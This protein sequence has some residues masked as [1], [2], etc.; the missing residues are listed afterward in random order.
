MMPESRHFRP[1]VDEILERA[2][3]EHAPRIAL[4]SQDADSLT[5]EGFREGENYEFY[6]QK[7]TRLNTILE[8]IPRD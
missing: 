3:R 7:P 6:V 8:H 5:K 2:K 1:I 4:T